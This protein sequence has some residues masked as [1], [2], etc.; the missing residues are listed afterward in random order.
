MPC[1]V[2]RP[3]VAYTTPTFLWAQSSFASSLFLVWGNALTFRT[4]WSRWNHRLMSNKKLLRIYE[5]ENLRNK[6]S[7]RAWNQMESL[8]NDAECMVCL[9]RHGA[10]P[11]QRPTGVCWQARECRMP[12]YHSC[13]PTCMPMNALTRFMSLRRIFT[14][15]SLNKYSQDYSE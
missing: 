1:V 12:T 3:C 14:N 5:V 7:P 6:S 13:R 10:S 11:Q 9:P 8:Y 4:K 2:S 15:F